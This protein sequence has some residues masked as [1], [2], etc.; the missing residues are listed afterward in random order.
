MNTETISARKFLG[1]ALLGGL[2][3]QIAAPFLGR[4]VTWV[5]LEPAWAALAAAPL[6]GSLIGA[7]TLPLVWYVH[8]CAE[9]HIIGKNF[10]NSDELKFLFFLTLDSTVTLA[11]S[12]TFA[13]LTGVAYSTAALAGVAA[14]I[15]GL[16]AEVIVPAFSVQ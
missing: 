13:H 2:A 12:F 7:V 9:D 11:A 8:A 10:I 6:T 15:V 16:A 3:P 5:A 14:V 1:Q 4:M